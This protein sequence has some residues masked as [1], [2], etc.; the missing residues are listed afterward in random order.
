MSNTAPAR[1]RIEMV[2]Q[3]GSFHTWTNDPLRAFTSVSA[4]DQRHKYGS[5]GFRTILNARQPKETRS[6]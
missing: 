2:V 3:G 5:S 4:F 1:V 6:Q